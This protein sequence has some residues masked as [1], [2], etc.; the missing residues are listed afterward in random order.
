[1][2]HSRSDLPRRLHRLALSGLLFLPGCAY[3]SGQDSE[4]G[5]GMPPR[6]SAAPPMI[7]ARADSP[8]PTPS[9]IQTV[10]FKDPVSASLPIHVVS[11][12]GESIRLGT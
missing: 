10:G 6:L 12:S 1:M 3:L 4:Y 8:A 2:A 11:A 5:P 7:G 9:P